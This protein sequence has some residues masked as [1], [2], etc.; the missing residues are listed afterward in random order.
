MRAPQVAPVSQGVEEF[1]VQPD[2]PEPFS[3]Q[4]AHVYGEENA[5][6]HVALRTNRA[7]KSSG[8]ASSPMKSASGTVV[9]RRF[10]YGSAARAA[11]FQR[12]V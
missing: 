4:V 10:K 1:A 2:V 11:L 3:F 5:W 8:A 9:Q 7:V 12:Q 6:V